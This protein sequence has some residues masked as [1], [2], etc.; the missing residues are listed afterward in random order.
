MQAEEFQVP[1]KSSSSLLDEQS[2]CPT[3]QGLALLV[4]HLQALATKSD[5][6][7]L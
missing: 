7:M 1:V 3:Q 6:L 5:R 4:H 2:S